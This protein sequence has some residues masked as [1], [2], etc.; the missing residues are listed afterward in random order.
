VHSLVLIVGDKE[1]GKTFTLD[2][3]V[4]RHRQKG[5]HFLVPDT[6]GHWKGARGARAGIH[7][8]TEA[9][10]E[11]VARLAVEL[12]EKLGHGIVIALDEAW[13]FMGKPPN[14]PDRDGLFYSILRTGRQPKL[15]QPHYRRFP[16]T[17]IA[18]TQQPKDLMPEVRNLASR[19]YFMK[20]WG[21]ESVEWA[22]LVTHDRAFARS[23][24]Q[25]HAKFPR[26]EYKA[27]DL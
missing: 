21:P 26:F 6:M 25:L 22:E 3:L 7:R 13:R 2:W 24:A 20:C 12:T 5:V 8:T 15:E 10:P 9:D 14:Q 1:S 27:V 18:A 16:V 11:R 4:E 23:L 19:I 17:V